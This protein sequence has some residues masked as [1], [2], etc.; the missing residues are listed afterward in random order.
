MGQTLAQAIDLSN[1]SFNAFDIQT[2]IG[3][4]LVA[5]VLSLRLGSDH[6]EI[7]GARARL[8]TPAILQT[9]APALSREAF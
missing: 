7:A 9:E 6:D 3:P 4:L 5:E 2:Q 1:G 8:N